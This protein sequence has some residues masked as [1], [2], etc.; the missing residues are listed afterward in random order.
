MEDHPDWP[1]EDLEDHPELFPDI[2]IHPIDGMPKVQEV[3]FFQASS[4]TLIVADLLFN[5]PKPRQ[6]FQ[7]ILYSM[8]DLGGEPPRPSRLWRSLIKDD[9]AFG[10]SIQRILE[11]DFDRVIP[12]HGEMIPVG[13]KNMMRK[14]FEKWLK[15]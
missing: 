9:K 10:R 15:S 14:A 13:G 11:L 7:R 12:G 6:L 8:A 5:L 2:E 1:L 4:G 3:V